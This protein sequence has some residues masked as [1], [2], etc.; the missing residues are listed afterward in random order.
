MF[1]SRFRVF[2]ESN[3]VLL[4]QLEMT[5]AKDVEPVPPRQLNAPTAAL[6]DRIEELVTSGKAK[7]CSE[8][9]AIIARTNPDVIDRA[10][11]FRQAVE[12][13]AV[14]TAE[15]RYRA[16]VADAKRQHGLSFEAAQ[17]FVNRSQPAL[18][19]AFADEHN[20]RHASGTLLAGRALPATREYWSRVKEVAKA[21]GLTQAEAMR[22]VNAHH[23]DLRAS[24]VREIN[25]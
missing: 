25:S 20:A 12:T 2:D 21:K 15:Q 9:M 10:S 5:N 4:Q 23:A 16:A 19:Q 1:P 18:R 14:Q 6:Y 3:N 7:T 8:A 17:I 24:M 11:D 13:P 22:Y